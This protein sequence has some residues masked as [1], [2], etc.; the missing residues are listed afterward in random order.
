[1]YVSSWRTPH[2]LVDWPPLASYPPP[3]WLTPPG[4]TQ[5]HDHV[6]D[7]RGARLA[8]TLAKRTCCSVFSRTALKLCQLFL[9]L[10]LV[11]CERQVEP[12]C[13]AKDSSFGLAEH[14]SQL[15][16]PWDC[17][18]QHCQKENREIRQ[19]QSFP[20]RKQWRSCLRSFPFFLTVQSWQNLTKKSQSCCAANVS[21]RIL[22]ECWDPGCYLF[23]LG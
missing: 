10:D 8:F 1:M 21:W 15:C 19:K 12:L 4:I 14:C 20:V 7:G 18:W 9:F 23:D 16:A 3:R 2:S 13:C 6:M 11:W 5:S 22:T 17:P